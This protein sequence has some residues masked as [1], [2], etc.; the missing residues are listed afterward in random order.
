MNV[1]LTCEQRQKK[2]GVVFLIEEFNEVAK[3]EKL[4][5]SKGAWRPHSLKSKT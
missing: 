4:I 2:G 1:K 5:I 3:P